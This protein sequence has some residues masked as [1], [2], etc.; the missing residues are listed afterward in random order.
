MGTKRLKFSRRGR[1][2]L[3]GGPIQPRWG[4]RVAYSIIDQNP[5]VRVVADFSMVFDVGTEMERPF[6]AGFEQPYDPRGKAI[7]QIDGILAGIK[8]LRN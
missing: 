2:L 3:Q 4:Y 7:A 5:G 8:T 6:P 1:Q